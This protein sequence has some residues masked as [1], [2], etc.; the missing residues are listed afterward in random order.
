MKGILTVSILIVSSFSFGQDTLRVLFLGNSYTGVNNLPQ[1]VADVAQSAGDVLIFESNT[2]GGYTLEGH[3]TNSISLQKIAQGNWDYVVLQEQSQRPSFPLSQVQQEVFPYATY[4]DSLITSA[5]SCTETMFYMTW[6]R[7]NGDASNCASWP[8][9]CTYQGMDSLLRLRYNQMAIDNQ[10]VVSP[11]GPLWRFIRSN[12]PGLQLYSSDGS[13]PSLAGS[14]AAACSFYTTLF[15][16]D[17]TLITTDAGVTPIDAL[18]IR[19]SAKA[20][21]FDSLETW[22]IGEYDPVAN[23]SLTQ[24]FLTGAFTNQSINACNYYWDFGDGD[25]STFENPI[26]VYSSSGPHTIIL[27]AECCGMSDTASGVFYNSIGL[28]ENELQQI[29][30]QP[31][32][33]S[34]FIQFELSNVESV[35][36]VDKTGKESQ[37]KFEKLGEGAQVDLRKFPAGIY[38]LKIESDGR[39]YISKVLKE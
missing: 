9:V 35:W 31:N 18:T 20:V 7:E 19:N 2:P 38:W 10:G 1:L 5:N 8:P 26:H 6:G 34:D 36:I 12:A 23:F 15:R 16:K 13:H 22:H 21:V 4:L 24:N 33:T 14:Y 28:N 17:P 3:S 39:S 27:T 25:T 37:L 11:V 30:T 32:P 29:K